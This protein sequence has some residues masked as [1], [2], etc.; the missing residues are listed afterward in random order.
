MFRISKD[1]YEKAKEYGLI[2]FPG[3][4]IPND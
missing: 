1:G 3:G 4:D 2:D